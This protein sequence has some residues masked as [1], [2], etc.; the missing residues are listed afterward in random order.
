MPAKKVTVK[1]VPAKK[2]PAKKAAAKKTAATKAAASVDLEALVH[3]RITLLGTRPPI[4]REILVRPSFDLEETHMAIQAAMGWEN[5]HLHQ[6]LHYV[7][8]KGAPRFYVGE[9]M[10][11]LPSNS[12]W[13]FETRLIP[14]VAKGRLL[15]EYDFG[16]GWMHEIK[17]LG[18]RAPVAGQR[19][20]L[21][22]AGQG[23]CPPEDCGGP[24]GYDTLVDDLAGPK[25]SRER[26]E[27]LAML[28]KGFDPELFSI[29]KANKTMRRVFI[30][31]K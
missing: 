26:R 1:K 14:V 18:R 23:A 3:L 13:D 15:Y 21:V 27:A 12:E 25:N 19:L 29:D 17:L 9:E 2:G 22:L 16:D 6:F 10:D 4:W 28:P 30:N 24:H 5:C 7:D 8:R 20:P 31:F 11:E